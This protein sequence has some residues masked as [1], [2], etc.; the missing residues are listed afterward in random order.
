MLGSNHANLANDLTGIGITYLAM[1]KPH[2]AL[3]PL[4][5]SLKLRESTSAYPAR[6]AETRFALARALWATGE[7]ARAMEL[8]IAARDGFQQ[9]GA[10][11]LAEV[12]A[13]IAKH[14]LR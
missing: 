1:G 13:W 4:E 2:L 7:Q 10:L 8:A 11:E 14:P 6:L 12:T 9:A 5:R 3:V